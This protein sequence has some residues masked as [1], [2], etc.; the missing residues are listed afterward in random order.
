MD[1][2]QYHNKFARLVN[3]IE[4]LIN[5]I[6]G[7]IFYRFR[8]TVWTSPDFYN[9]Y[10]FTEQYGAKLLKHYHRGCRGVLI[11]WENPVKTH[12]DFCVSYKK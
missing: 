1:I 5:N 6:F 10:I 2:N 11:H 3:Y 4:E 7:P 9:V 8:P 12:L